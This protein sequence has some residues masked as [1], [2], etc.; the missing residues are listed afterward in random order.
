MGSSGI[1]T[2]YFF[3]FFFF[4]F[5]IFLP[6][7]LPPWRIYYNYSVSS[8]RFHLKTTKKKAALTQFASFCTYP[9]LV[10]ILFPSHE[11]FLCFSVVILFFI[12]LAKRKKK[13]ILFIGISCATGP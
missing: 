8:R 6:P 9:L 12:H 2:D 7:S 3:F 11:L 4:F 10:S 1:N 5:R 13:K